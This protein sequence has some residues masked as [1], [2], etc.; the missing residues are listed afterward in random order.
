MVQ[1]RQLLVVSIAKP[2]PAPI[3][4]PTLPGLEMSKIVMTQMRQ[5]EEMFNGEYIRSKAPAEV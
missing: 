3:P 1:Q 2:L 5:L 4:V